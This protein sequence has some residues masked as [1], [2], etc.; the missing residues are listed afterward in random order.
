[1][2]IPEY[3]RQ[4]QTP[5]VEKKKPEEKPS[6]K[7]AA[8]TETERAPVKKQEPAP[9][10]SIL[11]QGNGFNLQQLEEWT[12]KTIYTITGPV[13]D[14]IQHNVIINVDRD[15]PFQ[16]L[17]DYSEWQLSTLTKE[18][19]GCTLLSRT[20]IKLLNGMEAVE[21][22]FSWYPVPDIKIYQK[23]MYI[24]AGTTAYKMT[25]SFT[26]KTQHTIGP[27]VERMMLSF[28]ITTDQK[29]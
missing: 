13:T 7:P 24:L 28:N 18:L 20:D 8:V 25:A 14:G 15:V 29:K 4:F 22:Y 1:M 6:D 2:N 27:Q 10:K 19:K 11:F 3:Y 16:S 12:D 26:K 5:P 17:K 23:Q 9:A 21:A